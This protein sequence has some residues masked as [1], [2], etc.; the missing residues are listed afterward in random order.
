MAT[1]KVQ[2]GEP[3]SPDLELNIHRE[4]EQIIAAMDGV[5]N[6]HQ[7]QVY[8]LRDSQEDFYVTLECNLVEDLPV[9]EAHQLSSQIE[10]ELSRRVQGVVDVFVHLE[11]PSEAIDR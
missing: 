3:A 6:P 10:H 7:V 1:N 5:C 8:R 11:P 9:S 4:I 2:E